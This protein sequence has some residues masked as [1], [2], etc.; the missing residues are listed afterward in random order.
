M[1]KSHVTV[2]WR[3]LWASSK[4]VARR[5]VMVVQ[6]SISTGFATMIPKTISVVLISPLLNSLATLSSMLVSQDGSRT[7]FPANCVQWFTYNRARNWPWRK[8]AKATFNLN[9]SGKLSQKWTQFP[10]YHVSPK[11]LSMLAKL[12][13]IATDLATFSTLGFA[14]SILKEQFPCHVTATQLST[15]ASI[16]LKA[17]TYYP[18]LHHGYLT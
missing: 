1:P 10:V 17:L 13:Y 7:N 2:I 4:Q 3:H 18:P 16:C 6:W 12:K 9:T 15:V 5:K 14:R 8:G 11:L